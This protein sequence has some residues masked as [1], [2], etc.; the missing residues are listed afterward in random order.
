L[1]DE[2]I[3]Q[4]VASNSIPSLI[5]ETWAIPGIKVDTGAKTLSSSKEE[6]ITEGLDALRERLKESYNLGDRKRVA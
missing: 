6:K 3:K 1:Y 2:T 5:L 4:S